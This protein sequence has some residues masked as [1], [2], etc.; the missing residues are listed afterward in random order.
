M[1]E[2]DELLETVSDWS[3]VFYTENQSWLRQRLRSLPYLLVNV[4]GPG[5]LWESLSDVLHSKALPWYSFVRGVAHRC[6]ELSHN[7]SNNSLALRNE[8]VL[9]ATFRYFYEHYHETFNLKRRVMRP[10]QTLLETI[11]SA[12]VKDIEF[13]DTEELGFAAGYLVRQFSRQYYRAS[14]EK[15][16]LQHRVMTFGSDLTPDIIYRRA[17]GK[18]PEYAIRVKANLSEDFRQRLGVWLNAYPQM[19]MQVK[20]N[21]DEFMAAFWSGYMLGRVE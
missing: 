19:K 6:D 13:Q 2:V 4:Y 10:W 15:D 16:Y 20:K 18:L 1:V 8:A 11:G 3:R 17:L 14:D 7:L 12:P 5:F 21:S 9:Y